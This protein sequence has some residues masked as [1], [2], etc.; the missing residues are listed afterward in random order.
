MTRQTRLRARMAAL[1][2]AAA[3]LVACG[4]TPEVTPTTTAEAPITTTTVAETPT[5]TV[6]PTTTTTLAP[7]T[8][9]TLP[10]VPP[11]LE[12]VHAALEEQGDEVLEAFI[13]E[14]RKFEQDVD[15]VDDTHLGGV[16][17][18]MAKAT[19]K[20]FNTAYEYWES[21]DYGPTPPG[22]FGE[23][24][25]PFNLETLKPY[26]EEEGLYGVK[27]V[28]W[29]S[30]V[31][32]L[33]WFIRDFI[34]TVEDGN[35]K[36]V[37]AVVAGYPEGKYAYWLS[38]MMLDPEED[39]SL[40]VRML[41]DTI[42]DDVGRVHYAWYEAYTDYNEEQLY[43]GL[44]AAGTTSHRAVIEITDR[45]VNLQT[46]PE[47]EYDPTQFGGLWEGQPAGAVIC[48]AVDDCYGEKPE[49]WFETPK[50]TRPTW[51]AGTSP[52]RLP[53]HVTREVNRA[54]KPILYGNGDDAKLAALVYE[55]PGWDPENLCDNPENEWCPTLP[56]D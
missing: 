56:K 6:A 2:L 35:L 12:E 10:K 26:D 16:M 15:D 36:I 48:H 43:S 34:V 28:V 23:I 19:T 51:V 45:K 54:R 42:I 55:I 29:N 47:K 32:Y 37:D 4:N 21:F 17:L 9:T 44:Y 49:M 52:N 25:H 7:T 22:P 14:M 33:N 46:D 8:T 18:E 24:L 53:L 39:V 31:E 38:D 3:G 5:T 27:A 11:T 30:N 20:H 13:T 40:Y 41:D 50:P 1:I